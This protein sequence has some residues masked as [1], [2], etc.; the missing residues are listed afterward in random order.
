M[1]TLAHSNVQDTYMTSDPKN[2]RLE[3][4]ESL[5]RS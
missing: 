2:E 3:Y 4:D 1:I 5:L